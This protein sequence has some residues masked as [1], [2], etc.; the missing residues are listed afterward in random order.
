VTALKRK[1]A[2]VPVWALIGAAIAVVL[3][4]L[5]R[6][7]QAQ[8]AQQAAA[9]AP[10]QDVYSTQPQALYLDSQGDVIPPV[11]LP[12]PPPGPPPPPPP[13]PR[14]PRPPGPPPPP[15]G[16]PT[17]NPTNP[18]QTQDLSS[19]SV[20]VPG[21]GYVPVS[22]QPTGVQLAPSGGTTYTPAQGG[23]HAV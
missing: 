17:M 6:R 10:Q 22:S 11:P 18:G 20:Y 19:G 12:E 8:Q 9:A 16:R 15:S 23:G 21:E 7:R 3:Y 14:P 1:V 13:P 4:V 2:G 5:Y